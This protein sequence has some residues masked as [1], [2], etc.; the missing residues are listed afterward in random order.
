MKKR[1]THFLWLFAAL[2]LLGTEFA[3]AQTLTPSFHSTTA[4]LPY[5][6]TA[7]YQR[8]FAAGNDRVYFASRDDS[9]S[10]HVVNGMTGKE[11]KTLSVVGV[12]DQTFDLVNAEVSDDGSILATPLTTHANVE[13]G[14]GAGFF[15]I[16]RWK[17]EN[18]DPEKYI[19]YS[20]KDYRM[21]EGFSVV[22]DL[23]KNAV[24]MAGA[25]GTRNVIRW[26]VTDGVLGAPEEITVAES[27][28]TGTLTTATSLGP[29]ST[30]GFF[31]N[32]V[33]SQPTVCALD[34]SYANEI[35]AT[36]VSANSA[37]IKTFTYDEKQ[38][39][40]VQ[41]TGSAILI[42]QTGKQL[43]DLTTDD[44]VYSI[45][46]EDETSH[47]GGVDYRI[48]ADGS[49]AIYNFSNTKGLWAASTE[50]API[51]TD[52]S[53]GGL[54]LIGETV[55]ADYT[56]GDLN[57]DAEGASEIKWYMADDADG[58]N[59]AEI[60]AAA[61]ETSYTILE[62][63]LFKFLSFSVLPV[64]ATGT[65][66]EAAHLVQ[67]GWYGE[68]IP[69]D[70][71]YP[72][73]SDVAITGAIAVDVELTGSYTYAD[74]NDD[75]EGE[76]ILK[77][78]TA[79][80]AAGS[81]A[82]M[83]AE[84]TT[85]Y[86]ILPADAD[87]WVI[88]EVTPVAATGV[89]LEGDMVQVVSD[90]AVFFPAFVPVAS[91]LALSGRE[92]VAGIL[93]GTYTYSDLNGDAEGATDIKWY[94]ADDAAGLNEIEITAAAGS[95]EYTLAA[96]DEGKYVIFEVTPYTDADEMG[97]AARVVTGMI[98][99]QPAPEAPVASDVAVKGKAEVGVVL[100]GSYTYSDRTDDP[101]GASIFKWFTADDANG[102]NMVELTELAGQLHIIVSEAMSGKHIGF[103]V[104]PVATIG[105]L[106]QGDPVGTAT[107]D[108]VVAS[109]NDGDFDRVWFASTKVDALFDYLGTGS[110]ERGF[111]VGAE[112]LYIASRNGGTRLIVA[113][114]E[115]GEYIKDMNTTGMD[116]GLF[117]INDVEVSDDGQILACPLSTSAMSQGFTIYKWTDEDA[118]PTKFIEYMPSE[119]MRMGDRFNVKG[120][121]SGNA[122]ITAVGGGTSKVV[123]WVITGGVVGAAE[124]IQM[125]DLTSSGVAPGAA[126]YAASADADF[127]FDARAAQP[128]VFAHDGTAKFAIEGVGQNNNQSNSPTV[129]EFKG[130]TLA[131]FHEKNDNGFW[132]VKVMD[133]TGSTH[134][135]VGASEI[136]SEAN[137][138]LGG[139]HVEVSS[140][141]FD[142]YMLSANN[143]MARFRG[144]L[145]LPEYSYA[146]TM[147]DGTVILVTFDKNMSDVPVLNGTGWT[148]MVAGNAVAVDSL[149][150]NDGNEIA[151]LHL[152]AAAA[153]GDAITIAYDGSGD[154]LAFDGMPLNAFG[155]EDVVNIVGAAAPT[156][157]AVAVDG[158]THVGM[159]VTGVYTYAD[160]NSDAEGT[161][162][163][164]WYSANAADGSDALKIL[165]EKT[166]SYTVTADMKGKFF[167]FEVVPVALTG[168]LD[169]LVG[170]PVLST[171][172]AVDVT[173]VED[174]AAAQLK[175]YPN[176]VAGVLTIDN[177]A[178]YDRMTM[179]DVTGKVVMTVKTRNENHIEVD[180]DGLSKGLYILRLTNNDGAMEV[181]RIVKSN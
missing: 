124:V 33:G 141:Y 174:G 120:D 25:S 114:K 179:I 76:S 56:Y 17:D 62:A 116:V 156:A 98:A 20:E 55:T 46:G 3:S 74:A 40:L 111:A 180:M 100:Q 135:A 155:P 104:T 96:E 15:I 78:Y 86:K 13:S 172:V 58:T 133:I 53:V 23:T 150:N 95:L 29:N 45:I 152:A 161:S 145:V 12:E 75:L 146:E 103:E 63:D 39:I 51:A 92:E 54:T 44:I 144:T 71:D 147:E 38:Y 134:I 24:I 6:S 157:T 181:L 80:D 35:P 72:T 158:D 115:N 64:A 30:D 57:G 4:D 60:T 49:L 50:A 97:A 105:E 43:Q 81:N 132:G 121:V 101:E 173:G 162:T 70:A 36:L 90:S 118:A 108:A 154:V 168:G 160:A 16:Y 112:H 148:V 139:V 32:T 123:R 177:C 9:R 140:D 5:I 151:E 65:V 138:E 91:D 170:A 110:T 19:I 61:G 99:A 11:I 102:T 137:Q 88:F 52:V 22:G 21:G 119:A 42:N 47:F 83:V 68:I 10:L 8:G 73:A 31:Y 167:A 117:Y 59:A 41:D 169:Y 126:P 1:L 178:T 77:W 7:G 125:G 176:P 89:L 48:G 18:S 85:T 66:S 69:A 166:T 153:E 2:L 28:P 26:V 113:D 131:S 159:T 27:I 142:L 84:N 143:G 136:L 14:W 93:T 109:T 164:Q 79:D 163:F 82:T 106:L 34:G 175:A 107:A 128:Q 171:F 165:G 37:E 67:S 130:R 129:F 87:K 149:V 127:L 94:R 122:V